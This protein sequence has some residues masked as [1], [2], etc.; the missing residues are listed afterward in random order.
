[1]A[2][3]PAAVCGSKAGG[4]EAI[5]KPCVALGWVSQVWLGDQHGLA[6]V[7]V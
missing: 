5:A 7:E 3:P 2:R 4:G 6:Q 1:M